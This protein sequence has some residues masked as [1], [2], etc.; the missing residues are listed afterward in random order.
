MG[1]SDSGGDQAV[2]AH[3]TRAPGPRLAPG[4]V[5]RQCRDSMNRIDFCHFQ[6]MTFVDHGSHGD[7]DSDA[8]NQTKP[9]AL[10]NTEASINLNSPK[11]R[12]IFKLGFRIFKLLL[13]LLFSV[14]TRPLLCSVIA[15]WKTPHTTTCVPKFKLR[16]IL[17]RNHNLIWILQPIFIKWQLYVVYCSGVR[18]EELRQ[19][20]QGL[21]D[22]QK[23][24]RVFLQDKAYT[25]FRH[26]R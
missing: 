6:H 18:S 2:D 15:V 17:V 5:V 26:N 13:V 16:A 3:A 8:H 24:D 23:P 20:W 19:T 21:L 7:T 4:R 1:S 25:K 10:L 12:T 9:C 22:L 14:Y 11:R